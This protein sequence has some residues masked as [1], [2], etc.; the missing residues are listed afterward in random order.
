MKISRT[1]FI[2][3]TG[4]NQQG[5]CFRLSMKEKMRRITAT[6]MEENGTKQRKK[7]S[8]LSTSGVGPR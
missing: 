2:T 5:I 7:E 8:I 6:R 3:K 4:K 1:L